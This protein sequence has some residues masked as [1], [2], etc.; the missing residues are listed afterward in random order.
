V[1]K[2]SVETGTVRSYNLRKRIE[3]IKD[4]RKIGKKDMKFNDS[5]PRMRVDP[6]TYVSFLALCRG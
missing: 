5:R 4:C 1:S 2:A 3:I 6:E